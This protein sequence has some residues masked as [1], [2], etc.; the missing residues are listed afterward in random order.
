MNDAL[1]V[2]SESTPLHRFFFFFIYILIYK[3]NSSSLAACDPSCFR[4]LLLRSTGTSFFCLFFFLSHP[5]FTV[6]LTFCES[7][8]AG[9]RMRRGELCVIFTREMR[10]GACSRVKPRGGNSLE[11]RK[12]LLERWSRGGGERAYTHHTHIHFLSDNLRTH[13]R[14]AGFF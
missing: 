13:P 9:G 5:G 3:L 10:R 6:C 12:V 11:K 7:V 14:R 4:L 1:L 2:Q 8:H